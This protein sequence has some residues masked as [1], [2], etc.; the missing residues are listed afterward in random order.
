MSRTIVYS[1]NGNYVCYLELGLCK[2]LRPNAS[3]VYCCCIKCSE[4]EISDNLGFYHVCVVT[5][6][7]VTNIQSS[8]YTTQNTSHHCYISSF[9]LT[10]HTNYHFTNPGSLFLSLSVRM[11]A[12]RLPQL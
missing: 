1:Y 9:V 3:G 4:S 2:D 12:L 7:S 10:L 11:T 6:A 5:Y 8:M